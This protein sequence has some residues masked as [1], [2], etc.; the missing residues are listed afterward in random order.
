LSLHSSEHY[1]IKQIDA[2]HLIFLARGRAVLLNMDTSEFSPDSNMNIPE[3]QRDLQRKYCNVGS[4]V[5]A[6]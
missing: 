3:L 2:T 4:K 5:E 1:T 6:L